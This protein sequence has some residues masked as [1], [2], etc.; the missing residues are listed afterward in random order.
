MD[1]PHYKMEIDERGEVGIYIIII[2]SNVAHISSEY[3]HVPIMKSE[4]QK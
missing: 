4:A 1:F 3:A 2:C